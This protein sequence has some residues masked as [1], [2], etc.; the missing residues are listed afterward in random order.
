MGRRNDQ[1]VWPSA[2]QAGHAFLACLCSSPAYGQPLVPSTGALPEL[3]IQYM[4]ANE[5]IDRIRGSEVSQ[6]RIKSVLEVYLVR[7][8]RLQDSLG[9]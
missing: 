4:R 6:V 8:I 9:E 1:E 3:N 7:P 5:R 2:G